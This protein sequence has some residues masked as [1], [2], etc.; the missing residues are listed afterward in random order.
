MKIALVIFPLQPSHGSFLQ[1]FS[2]FSAMKEKGYEVKIIHRCANKT[3]LKKALRGGFIRLMKK[4]LGKYKLRCFFRTGFNPDILKEMN[5]FVERYLKNDLIVCYSDGD[6]KQIDTYQYDAFVVGSDQTW[7]PQY[8]SNVYNYFFD[9]VP[10]DNQAKRVSYA[11]SFGVDRWTFSLEQTK[12]CKNL[13]KRF[14]KISVRE[15]SGVMLCKQYLEVDAKCVLD[16]TVLHT[17]DFYI[18]LIED[19]ELTAEF[20]AFYYILDRS[21]DSMKIVDTIS[22]YT[23]MKFYGM[24][25]NSNPSSPKNEQIAPSISKWLSGFYYGDIIVADSYHAMIFAILFNKPFVII[26]NVNRGL[27]RFETLL[28]HLGLGYRMI[29]SLA[30]FENNIVDILNTTINWNEVNSK[31][32]EMRKE[33][34][35]FLYKA[36]EN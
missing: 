20:H 32:I 29:V 2:L 13:I 31:I 12:V 16:P 17:K 19:N 30:D 6:L 14:N 10:K 27:A 33:S 3:P 36:L 23:G 35:D 25:Q 18:P 24:N 5:R 21:V 1:T 34:L 8:V 4:I 9:F 28:D 26:G 22:K 7:R 15:E 11:S